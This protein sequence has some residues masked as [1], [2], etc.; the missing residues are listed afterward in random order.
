MAALLEEV[1]PLISKTLNW[2]KM[3]GCDSNLSLM[4]LFT[5]TYKK[6]RGAQDMDLPQ[7]M[8]DY[9]LAEWTHN[10]LF[11]EYLEMVIQVVF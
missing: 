6:I 10:C 11:Y 8:K 1:W 9:Q 5:N 4:D 7:Y 3:A 2:I